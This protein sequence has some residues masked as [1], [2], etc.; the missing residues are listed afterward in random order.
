MLPYERWAAV[1]SHLWTIIPLWAF[2]A[3]GIIYYVYRETSRVVC[4]HARQGI[5][6]QLAFLLAVVAKMI[7]DLLVQPLGVISGMQS[8]PESVDSVGWI[9]I[10]AIFG[11]YTLL[12]L[13]GAYQALRGRIFA[14]PVFGRALYK[15]FLQAQGKEGG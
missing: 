2:A 4:F 8:W 5:V 9:V 10:Y 6:F 13:Y 7:I 11:V 12:C 14:Y 1:L 3:N 15:S